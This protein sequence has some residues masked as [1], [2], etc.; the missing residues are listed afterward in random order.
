MS[1]G[2]K[3]DGDFV[4]YSPRKRKPKI[5]RADWYTDCLTGTNGAVVPNHA[6]VMRA[7]RNDPAWQ[8]VLYYDQ[9]REQVILLRPVPVHGQETNDQD[10]E[11]R[12][13]FDQDDAATLEWMQI[14]GL[15][16]VSL[17]IVTTAIPQRAREIERHPVREW[18]VSLEW[19]LVPRIDG[20]TLPTG[21]IIEP[22]LTR[23]FGSENNEYSL[24]VGKAWPISAVARIMQPGCKADHILILEGQQSSGK[25]TACRILAGE[26]FFSESLPQ[27]GSKDALAHLRGKWIVELPELDAMIRAEATATKAFLTQQVDKYRPAYGRHEVE[28][29]RQCVFIGTTNQDSYLKDETGGR[30]FWPVKTGSIDLDALKADR[31]QIWAEAF[32]YYRK[33]CKWHITD[34]NLLRAAEYQQS[35]RYDTDAWQDQIRF[36]LE[37]KD[38]VTIPEIMKGPLEIEVPKMHRS[39]QNRVKA[40]LIRLGWERG[41]HTNTGIQWTR[42]PTKNE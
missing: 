18:L 6:N 17:Q 14:A 12:P 36:Y 29:K 1:P 38:Q 31:E 20:G 3:W 22:W 9:L 32:H 40:I 26:A 30:R 13:W 2:K 5:A 39:A 21:E 24:A 27:I 25:S 16:R 41:R 7:L 37:G 34:P 8:S 23:Y 33:G 11:P 10:F 19:D 4:P 15:P 28:Y 42:L 35:L